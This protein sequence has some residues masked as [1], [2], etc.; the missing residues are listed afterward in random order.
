MVSLSLRLGHLLKQEDRGEVKEDREEISAEDTNESVADNDM[1]V[2]EV[3]IDKFGEMA[4]FFLLFMLR[5][6]DC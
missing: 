5:I 4:S 2:G 6:L 1:M 3:A